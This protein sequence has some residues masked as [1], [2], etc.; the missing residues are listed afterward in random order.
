[1][2]VTLTSW[3]HEFDVLW[4]RA[5]IR[6]RGKI[7]VIPKYT[8]G[9]NI[10]WFVLAVLHQVFSG[11]QAPWLMT[12]FYTTIGRMIFAPGDGS[13]WEALEASSKWGMF[14]HELSHMDE[15]YFGD[16]DLHAKGTLVAEEKSSVHKIMYCWKYLF[17]KLPIRYASYRAYVE[18]WGYLQQVRQYAYISSGNI[19]PRMHAMIYSYLS[20]PTYAWTCTKSRAKELADG[21]ISQVR[22]ECISGKLERIM[23][24]M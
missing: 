10:I 21:V 23:F 3:A 17:Y 1:M 19:S 4:E 12:N 2:D 6:H 20:G 8:A 18:R 22:D 14:R 24:P 9:W 7:R 11:F 13:S 5:N 16:P 15:M